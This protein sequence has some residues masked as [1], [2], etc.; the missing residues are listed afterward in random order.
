MV[1]NKNKIFCDIFRF[2]VGCLIFFLLVGCSSYIRPARETER[3]ATEMEVT[4][5]CKCGKCCGWHRDWVKFG[6]PVYSYGL[7]KG[8]SKTVGVTASGIRVHKGT[9]A[10]DTSYYPFGTVMYVPG[11]GWGRVEDTG[12]AIQGPGRIDL[13]FGSHRKALNWGRRH[14]PVTVWR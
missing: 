6:K 7:H 1:M 2:P 3:F 8:E 9:I 4:A 11:Y 12:G 13:Y 14:R 5:Y 10:A